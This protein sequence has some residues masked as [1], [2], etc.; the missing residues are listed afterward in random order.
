[1]STAEIVWSPASQFTSLHHTLCCLRQETTPMQMC[2]SSTGTMVAVPA[3]ACGCARAPLR[4]PQAS[5]ETLIKKKQTSWRQDRLRFSATKAN[6]H[7]HELTVEYVNCPS[8]LDL[9]RCSRYGRSTKVLH[10]LW[11]SISAT[12]QALSTRQMYCRSC[13]RCNRLRL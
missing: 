11:P 4:L 8:C 6:S 10:Q 7:I 3:C 13:H 5:F 2:Y 9:Y 1:M 12:R